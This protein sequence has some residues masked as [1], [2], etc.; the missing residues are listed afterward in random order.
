MFESLRVSVDG[1]GSGEGK[2]HLPLDNHKEVFENGLVAIQYA[3]AN[4]KA[5]IKY[6][7]NPNGS[8]YGIAGLCSKDGRHM[9]MMPH[10]ERFGTN[11]H[12]PYKPHGWN[13]KNPIWARSIENMYEWLCNNA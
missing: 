13:F 8:P 7:Q 5:T 1:S 6:P 10:I 2:V 11:V 9:Y 3:D 12:L 4:G